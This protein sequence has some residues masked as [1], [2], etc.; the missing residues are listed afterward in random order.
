MAKA[1]ILVVVHRFKYLLSGFISISI[2]M[3]TIQIIFLK[4]KVL[5]FTKKSYGHQF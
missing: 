2:L 1:N 5:K 4:C 3:K